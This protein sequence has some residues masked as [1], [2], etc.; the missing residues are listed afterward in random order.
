[1]FK[2]DYSWYA[3]WTLITELSVFA[4]VPLLLLFCLCGAAGVAAG[5]KPIPFDAKEHLIEYNTE[6]QGED[7]VCNTTVQ[8]RISLL[9]MP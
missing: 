3:E 7:K 5:F 6:G 8:G 9:H 1:M 4:V 2:D